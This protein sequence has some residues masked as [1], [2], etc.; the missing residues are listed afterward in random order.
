MV[1][2]SNN[3]NNSNNS[4]SNNNNSNN[5]TNDA[6][7]NNDTKNEINKGPHEGP[8]LRDEEQH[9]QR[10][11]DRLAEDCVYIHICIYIYI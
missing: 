5:N 1:I 11:G 6:N 3:S 2:N 10:I 8:E 7:D 9:E 4:S